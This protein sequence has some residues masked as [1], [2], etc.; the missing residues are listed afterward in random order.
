[1]TKSFSESRLIFLALIGTLACDLAIEHTGGKRATLAAAPMPCRPHSLPFG[2][3]AP[4]RL[5]NDI[6]LWLWIEEALGFASEFSGEPLS[7]TE[8]LL[9]NATSDSLEPQVSSPPGSHLLQSGRWPCLVP[10]L[11][12]PGSSPSPTQILGTHSASDCEYRAQ[13]QEGQ[14]VCGLTVGCL[15][16]IAQSPRLDPQHCRR[17]QAEKGY[18]LPKLKSDTLIRSVS[19]QNCT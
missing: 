12:A 13:S 5:G 10:T 18:F 4:L 14:G 1:M 11:L 6:Q 9:I 8:V 3:R 17:R 19:H 7:T 2:P 16:G 15:P